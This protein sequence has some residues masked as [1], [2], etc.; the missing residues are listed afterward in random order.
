MEENQNKGLQENDNSG[1]AEAAQP[2]NLTAGETAE[3]NNKLPTAENGLQAGAE[4]APGATPQGGTVQQYVMPEN[5]LQP[6]AGAA[7]GAT[8]QSGAYQ[9]YNMPGNGPWP[10]PEAAMGGAAQWNNNPYMPQGGCQVPPA[11]PVKKKKGKL[12]GI[13][14]AIV[15]LVIALA[16]IGIWLAVSLLGKSPRSRLANGFRNWSE[17]AAAYSNMAGKEVGWETIAQNLE[18]GAVSQDIK[19]NMTMP[20]LSGITLGIDISNKSDVPNRKSST[21]IS[22]SVA[23]IELLGGQLITDEDSMYITVPDLTEK[24]LKINGENLS[25]DFNASVWSDFFRVEL[26]EDLFG[27]LDGEE[28]ELTFSEQFV[29]NMTADLKELSRNMTIEAAD[30]FIEKNYNGKKVKCNGFQVVLPAEDLNRMLEHIQEEFEEGN[31]RQIAARILGSSQTADA[32][33]LLKDILLLF[34]ARY[35]SDFKL[36]IYLDSRDRIVHLA[37]PETIRFKD[38][39]VELGYA[40]DFN[41]SQRTLDEVEGMVKFLN[42]DGSTFTINFARDALLDGQDYTNKVKISMNDYNVYSDTEED[43]YMEY[44]NIWKGAEKNVQIEAAIYDEEDDVRLKL[45][46]SFSD[47]VQGES[48]VFDLSALNLIYNDEMML[49]FTG[50]YSVEP[51]KEQIEVPQQATELLYMNEMEA[52]GLIME[53]DSNL[54]KLIKKFMY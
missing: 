39:D 43:L 51:L 48:L 35:A 15:L 4:A 31:G 27:D 45:E 30:T 19:L 3:E 41:G 52:A 18:N 40:F 29:I 22:A 42:F 24:T 21:D 7:P 34:D 53:I 26:E 25:R 17:E 47:V 23:N 5:G 28:E 2:G 10:N 14:I 11:E 49:K 37:T 1:A 54:S 12:I 6:G 44:T 50:S 13:I 32:D 46:G 33:E 8:P 16:A 36:V 20:D 9:Q 38:S